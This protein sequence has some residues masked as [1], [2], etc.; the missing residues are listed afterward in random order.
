M[1]IK[2]YVGNLSHSVGNSDLEE[3]FSQAGKVQSVA[4]ITD[5]V[6]GKSKAFGFV[7]MANAE[8]VSKA[9][10][11]FHGTKLK[12]SILKVMGRPPG[13]R[14]GGDRQSVPDPDKYR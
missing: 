6:S 12:G 7:K 1:P 10:Q 4:V 11:Q 8:E 3:M 9:I 13:D 5:K 14:Q 2:L